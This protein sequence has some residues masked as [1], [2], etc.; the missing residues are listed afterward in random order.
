MSQPYDA[1]CATTGAGTAGDNAMVLACRSKKS[2]L[3]PGRDK[4]DNDLG[5]VVGAECM[6]LLAQIGGSLAAK[7]KTQIK[8]AV[9]AEN[10]R[11]SVETKTALTFFFGGTRLY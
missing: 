6:T 9:W 8:V 7:P 4:Q 1:D 3:L 2:Y 10:Q 11:V 5:Y